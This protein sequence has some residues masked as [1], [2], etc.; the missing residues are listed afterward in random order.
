MPDR[1]KS[2]G[3]LLLLLRGAPDFIS[4]GSFSRLHS[5]PILRLTTANERRGRPGTDRKGE[6]LE[7]P[8]LSSSLARGGGRGV[9]I[10]T[11]GRSAVW[12]RAAAR[13]ANRRVI[14]SRD[15]LHG[16]A[17]RRR[18]AFAA[19][20][21]VRWKWSGLEGLLQAGNPGE[22]A[23]ARWLPRVVVVVLRFGENRTFF[24]SS[25]FLR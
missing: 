8:T 14:S 4:S 10:G 6:A 21:L 15:W 9:M 13:R 23:R 25:D 19:G 11:S 12:N 17:A 16:H 5:G 7:S 1:R 18:L 3:R 22:F 24:F 2:R 20:F